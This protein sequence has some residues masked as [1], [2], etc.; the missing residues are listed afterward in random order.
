MKT[1]DMYEVGEEVMIKAKV[2]EIIVENGELK[3]RITAEHSN[4]PLDHKFTEHQ[5]TPVFQEITEDKEEEP[6]DDDRK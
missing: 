5:L 6:F 2:T 3:Y 1:V 4:N